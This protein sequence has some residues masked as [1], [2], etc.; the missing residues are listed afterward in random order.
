[1][2]L[3][4]GVSQCLLTSRRSGRDRDIQERRSS[5]D[6]TPTPTAPKDVSRPAAAPSGGS[7]SSYK[8]A[9]DRAAFI[10]QQA[11]QRMAERLAALGLKP[12]SKSGESAQQRQERE[13]REREDRVRQ[14]EAE[15]NRREQERQRRL[16]DERTSPPPNAK[17]AAKKPP[18]P[19][20]RKNRAD[21]ASQ[22]ADAKRKADEDALAARAEQE[23]KEQAIRDQQAAQEAQTKAI[24]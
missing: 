23:G 7:Y 14:A 22:R 18:P 19:P 12:P 11:E 9:E 2:F 5:R 24:E 16:A 21:S 8:T 13:T 6:T 3:H 4:S 10:K 15:D 20:S 1:M 17:A